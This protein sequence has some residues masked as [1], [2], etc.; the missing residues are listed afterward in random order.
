VAQGEEPEF[1]STGGQASQYIG[2]AIHVGK[3]RNTLSYDEE[4]HFRALEYLHAKGAEGDRKAYVAGREFEDL[5]AIRGQK[6][7]AGSGMPPDRVPQPF[8]LCVSHHHSHEPFWS[9]RKYWYLS[10]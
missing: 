3:W 1:R 5:D 9:P 4:T 6:R 2:N 10:F 8:F 7:P